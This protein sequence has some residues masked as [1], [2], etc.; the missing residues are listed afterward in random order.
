MRKRINKLSILIGG[1]IL[2][3]L[4]GNFANAMGA[5]LTVNVN[6][7]EA[8]QNFTAKVVLV[9]VAAWN[10][11]ISASGPVSGCSLAVADATP[12]AL[13]ASKT[14]STTC[15]ATGE[16]TIVVSLSGDVTNQ[17]M[18]NN[19]IS[20][21]ANVTARAITQQPEEPTNNASATTNPS[22]SSNSDTS[23]TQPSQPSN[24]SND[25]ISSDTSNKNKT[26]KTEEQDDNIDE[27]RLNSSKGKEKE[28][29]V[30][31]TKEKTEEE[32]VEEDKINISLIIITIV[33]I[34]LIIVSI[35]VF[36]LKFG[37]KN[38]SR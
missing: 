36:W 22:G 18:I 13:N 7:V 17:D 35:A 16:G 12:D 33:I 30:I 37:K 19:T 14:F 2:A 9:D 4:S 11:H 26:N 8:G 24:I 32:V 23:S 20:G 6:S 5:T 38:H 31:D 34:L 3:L 29:T 27:N 25:N 1:I 21:T 10:V 28:N 15:T